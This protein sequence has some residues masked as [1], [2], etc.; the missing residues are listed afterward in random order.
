MY[1]R[2]KGRI[3]AARKR[4]GE[5]A[6]LGFFKWAASEPEITACRMM[7][8]ELDAGGTL[9]SIFEEK[10]PYGFLLDVEKADEDEYRIVFG[11]L[12]GPDAGDGAEWLI[13]FA[14]YGEVVTGRLVEAWIN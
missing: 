9:D 6:L 8:R 12:A 14:D 11:C 5:R 1:S 4:L 10:G 13:R 3:T 7:Q 2:N